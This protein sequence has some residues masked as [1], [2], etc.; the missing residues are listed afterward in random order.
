MNNWFGISWAQPANGIYFL[1]FIVAAA[2]VIYRCMRSAKLI[3]ILGKTVHGLRF[4][5]HTSYTRITIK[6]ILWLSALFFIFLTLL[7]PCWNTK[8]EKV[9]QEGRDLFIALDISRSMLA[10]DI[11]PS[12]LEFAKQKIAALVNALPSE[13]IGLILFSGS[14]FVQCPLTRDRSAFFMYL[15]QIDVDTIASGTTALDQ[16]LGQALTAFKQSGSQKNKLLVIFT[17]G[18]DFSSNLAS[19][20]QEAQ[21]QGL[22]IFTIG[23]GT[24]Q[25]APIPLFDQFGKQSGH[26]KDRNGSVVIS[27]LNEGIL[28][29]LAHDLGGIYL[30][31]TNDNHDLKQL[32]QLVQKHEKEM[33]EERTMAQRE[34]QY[35]WFLLISFILLAVEWLV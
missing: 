23:I 3:S 28:Q 31:P 35:P 2:L 16:A 34:E 13:R 9:I 22:T 19:Y 32:V 14:S 20:K 18:E 33:I 6:S 12:R 15:N 17:D 25:G 21:Q 5:H 4:L 1:L 26:L 10:Q 27:K 7:H 11:S 29:A 30:H 8:D 24:E